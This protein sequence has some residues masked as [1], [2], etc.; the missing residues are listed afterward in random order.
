MARR[1]PYTFKDFRE[2]FA[3]EEACKEFLYEHRFPDGFVCPHCGGTKCSFIRTRWLYQCSSCRKQISMTSGTVMHRTHIPLTSW[4][5]AMYLCAT[6]KRGISAVQ[7]QKTLDICY[8]S[9]WYL[10]VR[11]RSAMGQRDQKYLLSDIVEMDDA[12]VGGTTHDGKRGRGTDQSPIAVAHSKSE[13]GKPRFLRIGTLE[14]LKHQSL[15]EFV[16]QNIVQDS[17]I[18]C[19]GFSSYKCLK[20]CVLKAKTYCAADDDL[21]WVHIA[22]SNLKAFLS[23]TYHGRATIL[24]PYFDEFCFRYNRRWF[25]SQLFSRLVA[26]AATS[27]TLLS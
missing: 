1:K 27:C 8:E 5:W 26:A 25:P 10:L 24:Q 23:G 3:T 7:L 4:F 11:I 20:N 17:T 18:E 13:A 9:A 21:K 14:N 15:Q 19:D 16:D 22:I 12:Y 2:Q 6:D